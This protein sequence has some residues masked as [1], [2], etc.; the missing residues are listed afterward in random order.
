MEGIITNLIRKAEGE[1]IDE[2]FRD[3]GKLLMNKL[4]GSTFEKLSFFA[5][6]ISGGAL[7]AL[8]TYSFL[9][10]AYLWLS[11]GI[12]EN[13]FI[14]LLWL[15]FSID[16]IKNWAENIQSRVFREF[17]VKFNRTLPGKTFWPE[18]KNK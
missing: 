5:L 12:I 1:N 17:I 13:Y 15:I 18:Q 9:L 7:L 8:E 10:G 4:S 6:M 14:T 3:S 11:S 16:M 2:K